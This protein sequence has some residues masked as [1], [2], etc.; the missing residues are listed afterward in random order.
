[1]KQTWD[2]LAF[3]LEIV[4]ASVMFWALRM[5]A[6]IFSL[7]LS[8]GDLKDLRKDPWAEFEDVPS[9]WLSQY[10]ALQLCAPS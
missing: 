2:S 7:A 3:P 6:V 8:W 10:K 9:T 1:M 5:S 4:L